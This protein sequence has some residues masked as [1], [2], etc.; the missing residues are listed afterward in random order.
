VKKS[1][2]LLIY[3]KGGKTDCRS[4]KGILLLPCT[5]EIVCSFVLS[6]STRYLEEIIGNHERGFRR[7]RCTT[8]DQIF[9]IRQIIE[10]GIIIK[11]YISYL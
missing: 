4:C 11:Q 10:H 7:D 2:I 8:T 5:Y 3:N 1:I 9:C 6:C